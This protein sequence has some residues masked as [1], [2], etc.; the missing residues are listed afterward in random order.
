MIV[1]DA[2]LPQVAAV[3]ARKRELPDV[4][5][6]QMPTRAYPRDFGAHLFGYVG[7]ITDAQLEQPDFRGS[8][9]GALIGQ[10]GVE[11]T[12][13]KLLMG[14]DGARVVTVNSIGR[15]ISECGATSRSK[16]QRLQLTIDYDVQKAAQDG[17][18]IAGYNGSA[19]M[20]DPRNGEILS[21]ISLPA[22]DPNAF[23]GGIDA[24]RRGA[25]C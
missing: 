21:L 12:Y 18:R 1:A 16:A 15:E 19:V 4:M 6:E 10:A 25:G 8:P 7:E 2:S 17:F 13:N 9:P 3:A 11:Q 22:F 24:P 20:L 14:Q 23:S 5:L